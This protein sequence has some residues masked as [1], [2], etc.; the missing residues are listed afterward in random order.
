[1]FKKF[2]ISLGVVLLLSFSSC[3]GGSSDKGKEIFSKI[4]QFIGIPYSIVVNVCQDSN[5]D[6]VCGAKELFTKITIKKGESFSDILEKIALTADGKYFLETRDPELPILVEFRDSKNIHYDNGKFTLKFNG[7]NNEQNEVKEISAIQALEDAGYLTS[8]ETRA[9][10]TVRNREVLD[11]V[12]FESLENNYNLLRG[13]KLTGNIARDKGLEAVASG[14]QQLD[15]SRGLPARVVSC[16]E[17][18]GCIKEIVTATSQELNITQEEAEVIA[19]EVKVES[20]PKTQKNIADGYIAHLS[21]PVVAQCA[22]GS[23]STTNVGLKGAILFD[24]ALDAGCEITVPSSTIIDSN[25]NGRYDNGDKVLGFSM[26][27]LADG[28]FITPLTTLL[29]MKELKGEDVGIFKLMVKDF[30]PVTA[31]SAVGFYTGD[32]KNQV[33]KLMLLM[34]ILK[35][36]L[37]EGADI[38]SINLTQILSNIPLKDMDLDQLL[39]GLSDSIKSKI[40]DVLGASSF[41]DLLSILDKID[42]SKVNLNT[43]IVNVSDGKKGL[44]DAIKESL[45]VSLPT[46]SSNLLDKVL[47]PNIELEEGFM[48]FDPTSSTFEGNSSITG[49]VEDA[50]YKNP[51]ENVTIK[52][53]KDAHFIKEVTTDSLGIYLFS[54]LIGESGY[55]INISKT[56]YLTVNYQDISLDENLTKHL[57]TILHIEKTYA[58]KGSIGGKVVGSI[59]GIGRSGITINFRK[60]INRRTGDI[61]KTVTTGSGGVYSVGDLDAGSYTGELQANGYQTSYMTVIVLGGTT[62][63]NQDGTINPILAEGEIRIVLTWGEKPYDLDSHLTGPDERGS[64]F[65]IYFG[66]KGRINSTPY[67]NLD[68]DD[69]SSYGPETVTIRRQQLGVYRYWVHDYSNGGSRSS[70]ALSNSGATVKVYNGNGAPQVFYVPNESG[71]VWKVFEIENGIIKPIN[72]VDYQAIYTMQKPSKSK[73]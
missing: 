71:T 13:E 54:N 28:T 41:K 55:S 36:A 10:R 22:D 67:A 24:T 66:S 50:I 17:N 40:M 45:K 2:F 51:L 58:G 68:I 48:N 1:M 43:L 61:V 60:G 39:G 12:I 4:L 63:E 59:D 47:K 31:A 20:R 32:R 19:D 49:K 9:L 7:F 42:T 65:H 35:I 64:R 72:D 27:G 56:D 21:S 18:A 5:L 14:L 62:Q 26:K 16:G 52:L 44:N 30:N 6:G 11:R 38:S 46:D 29:R 8:E 37:K 23:Y 34:E 57:E 73:K 25:N 15:I 53:Y 69:V 3:G 70:S 33:Q